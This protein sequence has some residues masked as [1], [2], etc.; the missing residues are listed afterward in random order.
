LR[1]EGLPGAVEDRIAALD[2]AA[3]PRDL[4][5]QV[6]VRAADE[7]VLAAD[8]PSQLDEASLEVVGSRL[9]VLERVVLEDVDA[10]PGGL[11]RAHPLGHRR[12]LG[13]GAEPHRAAVGADDRRR[14]DLRR[15]CTERDAR[16]LVAPRRVAR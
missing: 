4:R 15:G 7:G 16:Q 11:L 13:V 6:E 2:L 12:A 3:K 8:L 1:A 9:G 14:R 10:L 5:A